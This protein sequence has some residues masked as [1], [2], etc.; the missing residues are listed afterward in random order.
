MHRCY[1][2]GAIISTSAQLPCQRKTGWLNSVNLP[3]PPLALVVQLAPV[4]LHVPTESRQRVRR[5]ERAV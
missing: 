2:G 1:G 4:V 3:F 5:Q